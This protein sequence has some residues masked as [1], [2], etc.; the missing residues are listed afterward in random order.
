MAAAVDRL[1]E[2]IDKMDSQKLTDNDN[3]FSGG[4]NVKPSIADVPTPEDHQGL[5]SEIDKIADIA[6]KG[7]KEC[8]KPLQIGDNSYEV[9][10]EV[11]DH[12]IK[13]L[14]NTGNNDILKLMNAIQNDINQM[15][16]LLQSL[17]CEAEKSKLIHLVNTLVVSH[18][19]RKQGL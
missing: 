12:F 18:V 1:Q 2:K 7:K 17:R 9:T 13:L 10:E 6:N 4:V 3:T 16:I 19:E 14:H 15:T 8:I 11:N 5:L